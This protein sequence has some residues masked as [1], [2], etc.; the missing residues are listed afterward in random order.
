[1]NGLQG[2]REDGRHPVNKG[3]LGKIGVQ[4]FT[5][6]VEFVP[7]LPHVREKNMELGTE[8]AFTIFWKFKSAFVEVVW[9]A[10]SPRTFLL[11]SRK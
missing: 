4:E 11:F 3:A 6:C 7:Q 2:K 9:E 1:M 10:F 5:R 8:F